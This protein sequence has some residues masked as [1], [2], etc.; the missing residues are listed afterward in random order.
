MK[1]K[2]ELEEIE[3]GNIKDH[4]AWCNARIPGTEL[5]YMNY[6]NSCAACNTRFGKLKGLS[7]AERTQLLRDRRDQVK[8]D[9][10]DI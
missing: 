4:C 8:S 9:R 5:W 6:G 3:S 2:I 10:L 1:E 7:D